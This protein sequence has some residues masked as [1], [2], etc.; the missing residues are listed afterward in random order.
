MNMMTDDDSNRHRRDLLNS[1]LCDSEL[2]D[3]I[4]KGLS[5]YGR[6]IVAV[7]ACSRTD[8]G[9][10]FLRSLSRIP[11]VWVQWQRAVRKALADEIGASLV[12]PLDLFRPIA[13]VLSPT[14]YGS[15]RD[16]LSRPGVVP[17]VVLGAGAVMT[18]G[19]AV[20]AADGTV[21][22]AV[23]GMPGNKWI[24]TPRSASPAAAARQRR[25]D[26]RRRY[27]MN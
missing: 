12:V 13:D 8:P 9:R 15:I 16:L 7:V 22:M 27:G 17:A 19:I 23:A 25:A 5:N 1:A 21:P 11:G 6:E 3:S 4:T 26:R 10:E 18:A 24:V 2:Y 20:V 14:L